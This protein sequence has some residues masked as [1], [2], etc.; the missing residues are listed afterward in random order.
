MGSILEF[1]KQSGFYQLFTTG[2]PDWLKTVVMIALACCLL[3][4]AI[5]KKF[6]PMLLLPIAFGMLLT[7]LPGANLYHPGLF[8]GGHVAW[9]GFSAKAGLI[10]YLSLQFGYLS[11]FA[12]A[13]YSVRS[14]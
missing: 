13:S 3:Y 7:N 11:E 9:E 5:V 8:E 6:E 4:L 2:F 12:D 14:L 1:L 10:D